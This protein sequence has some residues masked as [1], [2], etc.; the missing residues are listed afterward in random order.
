MKKARRKA[1]LRKKQKKAV[2]GHDGQINNRGLAQ[3][4]PILGKEGAAVELARFSKPEKNLEAAMVGL[5]GLYDFAPV[6]YV[7]LDRVGRAQEINFAAANLLA[8]PRNTLVGRPFSLWV[9]PA[10][11]SVF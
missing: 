3:R 11:R 9:V 5:V 4:F 7:S 8:K 10:D 2:R 6:P 1:A